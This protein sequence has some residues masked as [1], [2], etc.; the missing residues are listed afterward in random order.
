MVR[1]SVY[2]V[3]RVP[4]SIEAG[5]SQLVPDATAYKLRKAVLDLNDKPFTPPPLNPETREQ[6]TRYFKPFN[7]QLAELL[8][9]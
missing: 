6:L 4:Q 7:D 8:G 2:T 5:D 9:Q 1:L 3:S